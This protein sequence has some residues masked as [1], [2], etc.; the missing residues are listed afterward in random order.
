MQVEQ[1]RNAGIDYDLDAQ[2]DAMA[3]EVAQQLGVSVAYPLDGD[4]G[5]KGDVVKRERAKVL[6][7][8]L[9]VGDGIAVGIALRM[10]QV[11]IESID[12]AIGACMLEEIGILVNLVP[13][14]PQLF[15]QEG[16]EETMAA[17]HAHG[18]CL[19]LWGQR[20]ASVALMFHQPLGNETLYGFRRR[21]HL[22][23]QSPRQLLER[24]GRAAGV[25]GEVPQDFEVV[26]GTFREIA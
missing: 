21:G 15:D 10:A 7:A 14:V 17:D 2:A 12:E 1:A 22:L 8:A 20:N 19:A 25:L 11:L 24:D 23:V 26:L 4:R 18:Q 5:V 13:G 16:L 6:D 9:R 3:V